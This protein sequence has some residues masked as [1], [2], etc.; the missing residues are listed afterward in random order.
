MPST[1]KHSCISPENQSLAVQTRMPALQYLKL[2]GNAQLER[3]AITVAKSL[4][5]QMA[6]R[7]PFRDLNF[8]RLPLSFAVKRLSVLPISFFSSNLSIF[9]QDYEISSDSQ[10]KFSSS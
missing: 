7:F 5:I 9:T 8:A 1:G 2:L 10:F 3:K 6:K 4:L